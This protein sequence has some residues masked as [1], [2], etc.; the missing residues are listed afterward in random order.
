MQV[1][2]EETFHGCS[3]LSSVYLPEGIKQLKQCCFYACTSLREVRFPNSLE[4]I[5]RYA[6]DLCP[7]AF[8]VVSRNTIIE[9]NAFP[10]SC[11]I[12]YRDCI[13]K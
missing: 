12:L 13:C 4:R 1:I 6:F 10:S 3:N 7:L 5:E 8:V 2:E 9:E 11:E